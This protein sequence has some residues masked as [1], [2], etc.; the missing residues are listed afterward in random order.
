MKF[1]NHAL[2]NSIVPNQQVIMLSANIAMLLFALGSLLCQLS[3]L[4]ESNNILSKAQARVR[5]RI[6]LGL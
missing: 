3:S 1:E 5:Q 4:M 2:T 6:G